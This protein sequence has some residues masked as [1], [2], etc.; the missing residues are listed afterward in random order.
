MEST[1]KYDRKNKHLGNFK[2]ENGAARAYNEAVVEESKE[3]ACISSI[4][5]EI[6]D[7]SSEESPSSVFMILET[8]GVYFVRC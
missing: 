2:D 5:D 6:Y 3:F 4:D 8:R 7:V 1:S